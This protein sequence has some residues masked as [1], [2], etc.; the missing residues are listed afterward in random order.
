M[1]GGKGDTDV[2]DRLLG[3]GEGGVIWEIHIETCTLPYAEQ[4]ASTSSMQEARHPKFVLWDNPERWGVRE[5]AGGLRMEGTHVYLWLIHVN[6]WGKP[7]QYWKAII[8]QLK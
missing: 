7:P 3:E 5:V 2:K 1:Q 8:L 6:V 4:M